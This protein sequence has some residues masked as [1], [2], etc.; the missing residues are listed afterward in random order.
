MTTPTGSGDRS[1]MQI[2]NDLQNRPREME[3]VIGQYE[4]NKLK[5]DS[6]LAK[7]YL[8]IRGTIKDIGQLH[9]TVS[10]SLISDLKK[11]ENAIRGARN[12]NTSV[13]AVKGDSREHSIDW[14]ALKHLAKNMQKEFDHQIDEFEQEDDSEIF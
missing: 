3:R 14:D 2:F 1:A 9:L 12:M 11:Q 6:A 10:E 4:Q 7:I 5:A 8:K 13:H